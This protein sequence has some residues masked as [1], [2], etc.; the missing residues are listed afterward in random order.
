MESNE[1]EPQ[2]DGTGGSDGS[3]MR[4]SPEKDWGANAGLGVARDFV[5]GER[6]MRRKPRLRLR[7][8]EA[9]SARGGVASV[10]LKAKT[11]NKCLMG[12][13]SFHLCFALLILPTRF[14]LSVVHEKQSEKTA[15]TILNAD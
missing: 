7:R 4:M 1:I 8:D 6:A 14:S 3:C 11:C 12:G 13:T 10:R 15:P 9:C 2:E 5:R